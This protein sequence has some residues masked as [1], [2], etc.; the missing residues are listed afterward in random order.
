MSC[1]TCDHTMN[2]LTRTEDM[3]F[4]FCPRCGTNVVK[5]DAT[6]ARSYPDRVY[7]PKL[8]ERCRTFQKNNVHDGDD[9]WFSLGIAE[10]IN[11]L[12]DRR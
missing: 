7:I 10:S 6:A 12:E 9:P 4:Y 1:P 2:F 11:K 5:I 3:S 8:V